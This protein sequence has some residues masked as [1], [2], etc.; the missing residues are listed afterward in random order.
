[1]SQPLYLGGVVGYDEMF[2][3]VTRAMMPALLQA[4]QISAGHRVLDIATGT[5]AA[6]QAA[7]RLVG[8]T[9][10]AVAGDVS[11]TMLAVART[12]LSG[13]GIKLVQFDGQALPFSEACFDRVICQ[14]G[15]AFFE[16]PARGLAEVNRVLAHGGRAAVS[17]NSTPERSLFTRIG[18][19]IGRH[20]PSQ[21][22][23]LNRYA[24]IRTVGRLS[25]LLRRA[26]FSEIEVHGETQSFTFASFD[27]YFSGTEAGSGISGQ[28]YVKLPGS[29]KRAVRA[30][31]RR[32][33]PDGGRR[34]PFAVEME[35]LI[36]SG[37]K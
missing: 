23:Q 27:D 30:E 12:N 11:S 33:F 28:A 18:T 32:S 17:V 24:S 7:V 2:A 9:G 36:G 20:V 16:D 25:A 21:A 34:T 29:V 31:V 10:E 15:L 35:V 5:G 13:T 1:M 3:G 26:E 22:E 37:R 8:S 19:V 14:L 4:A 6:A